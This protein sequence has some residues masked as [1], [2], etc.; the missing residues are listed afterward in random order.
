[1]PLVP[2]VTLHPFDKWVMG[3]VG[4]IKPPGKRTGARYIITVTN[5]LTRWEED[6]LVVDCN[7]TTTTRFLFDNI[8][9]RFGCPRLLMSDQ[10]SHFINRIVSTLTEELQIQHKK[11]TLYHPQANGAMEAFNKI[12]E[13]A[14][15]KVCNANHK[16][17]DL[18][19]PI[20]LWEYHTTFKRLTGQRPFKLVYGKETVMPMEYIVP[21]LHIVAAIGMDDEA[22]CGIVDTT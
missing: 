4:P 17:W 6:A 19:I 5:Y 2:Q 7:A 10:G 21:I 15:T 22:T 13:H 18:K 20:V 11:S 14:L 9:T 12:L 1:M 16:D 3:F 8:V